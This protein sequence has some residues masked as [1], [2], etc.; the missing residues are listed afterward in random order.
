[1]PCASSCLYLFN[2][3]QSIWFALL[4]RNPNK[5]WIE[6]KNLNSIQVACNVI[7]LFIHISTTSNFSHRFIVTDNAQHAKPKSSILGSSPILNRK[8]AHL[9]RKKECLKKNCP[10]QILNH[11]SLLKY[12]PFAT[13]FEHWN[14]TNNGAYLKKYMLVQII[15]LPLYFQIYKI[16]I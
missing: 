2:W 14:F 16:T 12:H 1:M 9:I 3:I 13:N 7:N 15:M 8:C 5:F 10:P 6:F 4:N 11:L